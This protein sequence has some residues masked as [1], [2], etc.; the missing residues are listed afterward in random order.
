MR[1]RHWDVVGT[2]CVHVDRA[3]RDPQGSLQI[4]HDEDKAQSGETT[5]WHPVRAHS[6]LNT[7]PSSPAFFLVHHCKSSHHLELS[8]PTLGKITLVR[9]KWE[10]KGN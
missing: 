4:T 10:R 3:Q 8:R 9:T 5:F 2:F 6:G 7:Y 1:N